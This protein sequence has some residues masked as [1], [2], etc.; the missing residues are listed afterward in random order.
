MPTATPIATAPSM[1]WL[2]AARPRT[3]TLSMAPVAMGATLAWVVEHRVAWPAVLAALAGSMLIQ[4]GTNLHN[5][6][7]DAERGG[8]DASRVGPLRATAAGLLSGEAVKRAAFICFALAAV[9]GLY[10]VAVGGWPIFV[11][12]LAS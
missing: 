7:S 5:D 11:L 1:P 2:L 9:A 8:D 12:G 4:I 6:A 10:L 3:L